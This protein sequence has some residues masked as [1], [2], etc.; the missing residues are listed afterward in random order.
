MLCWLGRPLCQAVTQQAYFHLQRLFQW[1][2]DLCECFSVQDQTH[3][4]LTSGNSSNTWLVDKQRPLPKEVC[5]EQ[6]V[7]LLATLGDNS[8][9]TA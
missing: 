4:L 7:D 5:L 8:F 3:S 9:T 2:Q 1:P 6:S